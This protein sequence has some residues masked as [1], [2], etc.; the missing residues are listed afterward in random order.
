M[1]SPNSKSLHG[2]SMCTLWHVTQG[3]GQA[4]GD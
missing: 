1:V 4:T 2:L 3:Y